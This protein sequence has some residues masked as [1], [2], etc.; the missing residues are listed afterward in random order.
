[1]KRAGIADTPQIIATVGVPYSFTVLVAD[2]H[3]QTLS[4]GIS[5]LP[6]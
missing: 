1:M 6:S 2:P 3:G 4:F 5:N